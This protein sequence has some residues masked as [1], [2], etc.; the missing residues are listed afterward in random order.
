MGED[1]TAASTNGWDSRGKSR[2]EAM[3]PWFLNRTSHLTPG[4]LCAD[5]WE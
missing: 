5:P 3:A 2:Q 1:S 4:S